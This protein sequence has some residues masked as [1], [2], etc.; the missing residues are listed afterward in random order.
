MS[1]VIRVCYNVK[2]K[3][4]LRRLEKQNVLR[5]A[6]STA[7]GNTCGVRTKGA[8]RASNSMLGPVKTMKGPDLV[9]AVST[10]ELGTM[11]S[12]SS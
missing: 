1:D 6:E 8:P 12:K 7:E 2:G 11:V 5:S 3:V 10:A 4:V 9:Q